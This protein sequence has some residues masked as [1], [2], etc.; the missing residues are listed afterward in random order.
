ML[1]ACFGLVGDT[2]EYDATGGNQPRKTKV[3][4]NFIHELGLY[5]KQSSGWGQAKSCETE[6]AENIF[7]NMPR[8][9]IN[10]NDGLGGG[11]VVRD[12]IIFNSCRESGD[13]GLYLLHMPTYSLILSYLQKRI[14]ISTPM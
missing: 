11:N 7:F 9:A 12:N 1:L 8:A 14:I 10:F 3:I 6:I 2:N 5:E 4:G 13:H